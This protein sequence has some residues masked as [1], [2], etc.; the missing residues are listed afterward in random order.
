MQLDFWHDRWAAGK[1]GFHQ[2]AINSQLRKFWKAC[3]PEKGERVL[4]PLCGKSLDMLWLAGDGHEVVGIEISEIACRDF[5]RENN[6]RYTRMDG[7]PFVKFVGDRIALWCGDFFATTADGLGD[8]RAVYD[9]AALIALPEAMRADYAAQLSRL[10]RPSARVFLIS[11]DYDEH[12][13]EGPPF[14][15]PEKAVRALFEGEFSVEI[16]ARSSGPDAVGNLAERG[17]DTLNEK[18]YLLRRRSTA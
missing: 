12:K 3:A 18:V 10:L 5:Y 13:M 11:M 1:L 17:L 4:V 2:Q 14:S 6:L 9:R 16:I 8:T 7:A 15:V